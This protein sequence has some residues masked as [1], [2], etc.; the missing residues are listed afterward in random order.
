MSIGNDI[1]YLSDE[2]S[3]DRYKEV[4]F[5]QKVLTAEE[6]SLIASIDDK[7]TFLWFLWSLKEAAY[8]YCKR[9]HPTLQFSPL[10]FSVDGFIA[11]HPSLLLPS[12]ML[13]LLQGN[14][15]DT[16]PVLHARVRTP[17]SL[18]ATRSIF[19]SEYV[20]SVACKDDHAFDNVSWGVKNI[21]GT[22][23]FTQSAMVRKFLSDHM[24]QQGSI[25]RDAT[26]YF[27]KNTAQYPELYIND[28]R[29]DSL[30]SFTHDHSFI[31]Y[32]MLSDTNS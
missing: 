13:P 8:K 31:G 9:L 28:S 6:I 19:T 32:A 29:H 7:H 18:L 21:A 25:P 20:F 30:I 22:D 2:R 3:I 27:S 17:F 26:F 4:R 12:D 14:G 10:K 5:V 11:P 24:L 15:F 1:V 16:L 23:H